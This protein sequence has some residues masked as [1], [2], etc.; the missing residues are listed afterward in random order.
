MAMAAALGACPT[1]ALI[2]EIETC[3][4]QLRV[5]NIGSWSFTLLRRPTFV[6]LLKTSLLQLLSIS[7]ARLL[8]KVER[9]RRRFSE[10]ST[11]ISITI[12]Q[13][14]HHG[15]APQAQRADCAST[16]TARKAQ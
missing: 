9:S 7:H 13:T 3:L 14:S 2:G 1:D 8:R 6:R 5:E 4:G 10:P 12:L 11:S 15:R 16:T